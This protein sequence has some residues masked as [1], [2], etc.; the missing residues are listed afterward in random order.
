MGLLPSWFYF[1]PSLTNVMLFEDISSTWTRT[2]RRRA[3]SLTAAHPRSCRAHHPP[4]TSTSHLSVVRLRMLS[5]SSAPWRM[6]H[7]VLRLWLRM[8]QRWKVRVEDGLGMRL[9]H[10]HGMR[11]LV[12]GRSVREA[13]YRTGGQRGVSRRG[14]GLRLGL[15]LLLRLRRRGDGGVGRGD[16]VL[17]L[18]CRVD[19]AGRGR[20]G[21]AGN[22]RNWCRGSAGRLPVLSKEDSSA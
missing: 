1:S 19:R 5:S 9:L 16:R 2:P 11:A 7:A 3:R 6:W 10:R 13:A 22:R 8:L 4:R 17:R 20:V 21:H 18:W 14:V 12:E 15:L